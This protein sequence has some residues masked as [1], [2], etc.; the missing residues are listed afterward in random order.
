LIGTIASEKAAPV[1]NQADSY[2]GEDGSQRW[3]GYVLLLASG[4][5]SIA[6][7]LTIHWFSQ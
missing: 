7:V 2:P 1:S 5:V 4:S 6:L 3:L